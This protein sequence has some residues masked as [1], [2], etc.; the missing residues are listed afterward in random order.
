M[1]ALVLVAACRE[2]AERPAAPPAPP[3]LLE[4]ADRGLAAA[5]TFLISQQGPDGALRSKTYAAFRDGYSLTPLALAALRFVPASSSQSAAYR[6]GVDF[7]LTMVDERGALRAP[8][9]GPRYPLYSIALSVLV[10][11]VPENAA[12]SATRD[13]LVTL[14]RARQLTPAHG[15]APDDPSHG[16]WGYDLALD[17]PSLV[18]GPRPS[19]NLSATI[20]V[21]GALTLAGVPASD[22]ALLHA[23]AF[24]ERC[25]RIPGDAGGPPDGGFFFSPAEHDGNKAGPVEL[26]APAGPFRS[27]GS[28]TA[29]GVRALLRLG[30]PPEHPRVVAAA[31]WLERNFSAARN[32]GDF[33]EGSEVRRASSYYYWAW[34]AAH[35]LRAIGRRTLVTAAGEVRWAEALAAA[36]LER[37]RA[38]GSFVNSSTELREDDPVVATSFAVAALAICRSVLAGSYATHRAP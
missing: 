29:D 33:V 19:A 18:A 27:Y 30:L 20:F 34:S 9:N 1:L 24:V 26:A 7:L 6:K 31:A 2:P 5:G 21:L 4:R 37:Q 36:L 28:A 17:T 12:H 38:D 10:L 14:L 3:S 23:R 11:N 15:F 13:A 32:P 8:P 16:G 22:P 25:Q 35:A